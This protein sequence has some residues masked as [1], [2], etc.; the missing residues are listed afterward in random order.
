MKAQTRASWDRIGADLEEHQKK[1]T[2]RMYIFIGI[3]I[4]LI[5][6][7]LVVSFFEREMLV[8]TGE[9][10][11]WIPWNL[12]WTLI[13]NG[14]VIIAVTVTFNLTLGRC[15]SFLKKVAY[16]IAFVVAALWMID[17]LIFVVF[18]ALSISSASA[19]LAAILPYSIARNALEAGIMVVFGVFLGLQLAESKEEC[20]IK[21]K[22][23]DT[24]VQYV[25]NDAKTI[26]FQLNCKELNGKKLCNVPKIDSIK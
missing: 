16:G 7:V 6:G 11:P 20:D 22:G 21:F 18:Y 10:L 4:G 17:D 8:A 9:A 1:T 25:T 2:R 26:A 14:A 13:I 5:A 19:D 23:I 24:P 12:W 3:V 15:M